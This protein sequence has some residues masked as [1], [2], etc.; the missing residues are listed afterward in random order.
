MSEIPDAQAQLRVAAMNFAI[1][2]LSNIS[3]ARA[4]DGPVA[5][6]KEIYEFIKG[7]TK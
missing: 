4:N 5:L 7:E 1:E 3:E 2:Y 6:A